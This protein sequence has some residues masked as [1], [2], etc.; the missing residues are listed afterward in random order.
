[1]TNLS[2]SQIKRTREDLGLS[3]LQ[4]AQLFG[5]HWITVSKWEREVLT[6]NAYQ[7]ALIQN[8]R[9]ASRSKEV[10]DDL[11]NKL[12]TAGAIVAL[13]YLLTKALKKLNEETN[14]IP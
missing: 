13:A 7:Q 5:I 2:G 12:I 1:M 6:P 10:Q 9:K 8:F 4:F 11:L 14:A 3:Q